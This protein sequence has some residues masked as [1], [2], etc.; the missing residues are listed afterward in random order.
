MH[1]QAAP[2]LS[3]LAGFGAPS[4]GSRPGDCKADTS[5]V[6][7]ACALASSEDGL[8]NTVRQSHVN[9]VVADVASGSPGA[10][11]RCLGRQKAGTS[12]G[13]SWSAMPS[14]CCL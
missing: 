8:S 2:G 13:S 4:L 3:S 1:R 7:R 5:H 10:F 12:G 9:S 11:S 6:M 14:T